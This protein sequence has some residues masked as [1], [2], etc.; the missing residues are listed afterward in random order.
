MKSDSLE[1]CDKSLTACDGGHQISFSPHVRIVRK[2]LPTCQKSLAFS[3]PFA[4]S[5]YRHMDRCRQRR[6]GVCFGWCLSFP[7]ALPFSPLSP[8]PLFPQLI[9]ENTTSSWWGEGTG[10]TRGSE[11]W[12]SRTSVPSPINPRDQW[13]ICLLSYSRASGEAA[14]QWLKGSRT[15]LSSIKWS[16]HH[17]VAGWGWRINAGSP[18]LHGA[19]QMGLDQ[20]KG[21]G[22]NPSG[23]DQWGNVGD[24]ITGYT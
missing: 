15:S 16:M 8:F 19:S 18:L 3:V 11:V 2:F 17:L 24:S 6:N 9:C 22:F 14:N 12:L 10:Q 1:R 20:C 23:H 4:A 13:V 5:L 21:V 7:L